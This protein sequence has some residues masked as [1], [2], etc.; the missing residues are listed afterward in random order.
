[1]NPET[2]TIALIGALGGGLLTGLGGMLRTRSQARTAAR[3]IYAELTANS[4]PV[5]YYLVAATWPRFELAQQAWRAHGEALARKRT[6]DDFGAVHRGYAALEAIA[7]V[8]REKALPDADR[9]GLIEEELTRLREA[10]ERA[11]NVAAINHR[12]IDT[13]VSGLQPAPASPTPPAHFASKGFVP[14]PVLVAIAR[15]EPGAAPP[16]VGLPGD[17]AGAPGRPPGQP[18]SDIARRV[19]DIAHGEDLDTATLARGEG[20][21]PTGD[22]AVDDV[23]DTLGAAIAFFRDVLTRA[24]V[25][26]GMDTLDAVVHYGDK[27][28]NVFWDGGRVVIGDGDGKTL[29]NFTSAR[30]VVA[31]EVCHLLPEVATLEFAYQSGALAE[32]ICDVFGLLVKQ[33]SQ[34]ERAADA[35]WVL[36]AG[37]YLKKP[38]HDGFRSLADPKA[39]LQPAHM[40]DFQVLPNTRAG[41][42]GGVHVN[43]GIPGHA[44]YRLAT[45]LGGDAWEAAGPIWYDALVDPRMTPKPDF[46]A[47]AALTLEAAEARFGAGAAEQAAVVASWEAVGVSPRSPAGRN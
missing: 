27:F 41:D 16:P 45:D 11:G 35:D 44:F 14:Y 6:A 13:A 22:Q 30:E 5:R 33:Q 25:P 29:G 18:P 47:F 12:E 32:A 37:L 20:D 40:D 15:A 21:P 34:P 3:L 46:A 24:L 26:E 42:W 31:H 10:L 19:Y 9:K 4:A 1:M 8:A 17:I 7:F 39:F 28:N 23:Y 36:G 43:S 38:K 2:I